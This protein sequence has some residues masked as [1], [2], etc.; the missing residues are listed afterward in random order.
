MSVVFTNTPEPFQPVLS[1]GIYFTVSSS[2]YDAQTTFKFR[3]V[4]DL[5]V[6]GTFAFR[7]KCSPNPYGLG[8]IDLQQI[9]ETYTNSLPVS[10]YNN[11]PI[12]T[13]QTFPFSRPANDETIYY[14]VKVGYEYSSSE[15]TPITGFTGVGNTVGDPG[16]S[17]QGYK[18]FRSTM[19]T[20][21]RATQQS[22]DI[23]PFVLSG[24]PTSVFP[25]TSGLFL[26]NAP[27]ILDILEDQYFTLAFTNYYLNSGS[28]PT[29]LS[30]PYYVE[31]KY[32]D[33]DGNLILTE[34]YDNVLLNGGG[35]RSS[36]CDVYPAMYLINPYTEVDYN[37]LYVGAGPANL[38]NI[39]N[40]C[41]QY[42]V[43]LFGVFEGE[44]T[45]IQ[46]S[47][48]PTPTQ[49]PGAI[50]PSPTPTPSTTPPCVGCTEYQIYYTGDSQC[51][52]TVVNCNTGAFQSFNALP[53]VFY[54]ICSCQFPLSDCPE[55]EITNFGPCPPPV[56]PTRTPTM[57]P[58]PSSTSACVCSEY[59]LENES[60]SPSFY[61]YIDC[62]GEA[63]SDSLDPFQVKNICACDGTVEGDDAIVIAYLGPCEIPV[64][65]SV[66]PTR[67]LTPTPTLTPGCYKSWN[68]TECA[69]AC[70][71]G[72]CACEGQTSKTVYTNCSVTN[73]T[74]AFT[75]IFENTALTNPYTADFLSSG[76]IYNSTGSGVS[77]VCNVGGPC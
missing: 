25:T 18:T 69:G 52:V 42:T 60:A 31:Y 65:P 64:S 15:I 48:T 11:T 59:L 71:G 57:T 5:F 51:L 3:Y 12:Y 72:L 38:P 70:S 46:P 53:F 32:F 41:V 28:T 36:G 63:I 44:T 17:S 9:L 27:R 61:Q 47:P 74:G 68:I 43:Q 29:I 6:D 8:I 37:T 39:P 23:G 24:T 34:Q 73:L 56:S 66:T 21:G 58:T 55:L 16:F 22:F 19:G 10:F 13:H 49:S 1:D 62:T 54:S 77:L 2:T 26:T 30:E 33:D 75:E 45:P 4:Y 50:T 14:Q 20:N 7:G 76:S 40:N 35:P 67:T